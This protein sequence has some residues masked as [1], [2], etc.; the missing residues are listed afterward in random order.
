MGDCFVLGLVGSPNREGRTNEL[1]TAALNGAAGFG[2]RTE[3]VQMADHVVAACRDCLPWVCMK[4]LKCSYEDAAF[5]YLSEKVLSCDAL[6]L[7]TPVY[8]GDTSGMVR[9]FMLKMFRVHARKAPLRD[10]PAL[11][12]AV[13]GGT[14]NNLVAG[15]RP[16]YHFFGMM[17]MRG[18]EPLPATRFNFAAALRRSTELG[19]EMAKMARERRPFASPDERLLWYD[20]LPYLGLD[21]AA[22][23]RLLADLTIGALP[24]GADPSL[25]RGLVAADALLAGGHEAEA[26]R[27]VTR[28]Y[29]AGF[30]AF[31]GK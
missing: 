9:Y 17:Q 21:R 8:W 7:G 31:Q 12:I 20:G 25:A 22:E 18:I 16:L 24:E 5:E 1:V 14:G 4:N 27:E 29:D 23:R 11:G 30:R 2:A 10:V 26:A 3:I 15:L 6:V 28:V 19:G 13:A